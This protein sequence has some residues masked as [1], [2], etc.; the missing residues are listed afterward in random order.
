MIVLGLDIDST[1]VTHA[2]PE[3]GEDI[4]AL[5]WLKRAL[6]E[7]P[8]VRILLNTMRSGSNLELA[9]QWLEDR[10]VPVWAMNRNPTQ[11]L[12]TQSPKPHAHV[13]VDDRAVGTPLREDR[14]VDWE[15]FGPMLLEWLDRFAALRAVE[16]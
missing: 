14:C 7:H 2:Y 13:Y 3:M 6:R 16:I 15:K 10:G 5:P 9:R 4:G 8:E 11:H 12:W 1:V